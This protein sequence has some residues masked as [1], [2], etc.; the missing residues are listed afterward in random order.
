MKKLIIGIAVLLIPNLAEAQVG[1]W[2]WTNNYYFKGN[3]RSE[4]IDR[5]TANKMRIEN[6]A[7]RI[8]TK[9]SIQD[10]AKQRREQRNYENHW[11]TRKEKMFEVWERRALVEVKEK[12]LIE[13]GILPPKPEV[14]SGIGFNGQIFENFSDL[15]KSRDWQ[16]E[17]QRR[18]FERELKEE[19]KKQKYDDAVD[20]F[21]NRS[22][23][24]ASTNLWRDQRNAEKRFFDKIMAREGS[25][26]SLPRYTYRDLTRRR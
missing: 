20:F 9:W 22:Y 4:K 14:L 24:S 10:E 1:T 6:R 2:G 5:E 23:Y 15:Q 25:K 8:R 3:D 13:K 12:E 17:L 18:H 16:E 7:N 21:R 11:L 19:I 26:P